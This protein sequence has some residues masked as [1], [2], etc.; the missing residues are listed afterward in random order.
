MNEIGDAGGLEAWLKDKPPEFACVLA[1]RAALRVVPVFRYALHE[2]AEERLG[3]AIAANLR[4]L[5][6]ANF[7]GA[8]PTRAAEIRA[9]ARAAGRTARDGVSEIGNAVRMSVFEAKDATPEMQEYVWLLEGDA[10]AFGIAERAVDAAM[11]ALQAAVDC[12]DAAKG[13]AS[14][15]AV[16]ESC[17]AAAAAACDAIDGVRDDTGLFAELKG[18]G[19]DETAVAAHV[20]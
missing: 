10:R 1:A 18:E 13:I 6:A 16:L 3:A 4:V 9:A 11:H 12:G 14:R 15:D 2:E 19:Q 5:A 8:W 17:V 7:A 20:A